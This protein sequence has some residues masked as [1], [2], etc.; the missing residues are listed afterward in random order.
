MHVGPV[1]AQSDRNTPREDITRR[2]GTNVASAIAL[3][4]KTLIADAMEVNLAANGNQLWYFPVSQE[5]SRTT[6]YRSELMA[7]PLWRLKLR[8]VF[9]QSRVRDPLA[10]LIV[11][12]HSASGMEVIPLV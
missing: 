9:R 10:E 11:E 4:N 3:Y 6:S 7:G 2:V 12:A 1:T 8:G 5:Q